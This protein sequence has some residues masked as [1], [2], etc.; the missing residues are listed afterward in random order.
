MD[1]PPVEPILV[2]D[3]DPTCRL[4]MTDALE[5]AGYQVD[6]ASDGTGALA[7]IVGQRYALVVADV[8]MPRLHGLALVAELERVRPGVPALLISAFSD[9]RTRAAA[10]RL[11]VP[12]L[13]KPFHAEALVGRVRELLRARAIDSSA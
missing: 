2:V 11:G 8:S 4:I 10:R 13:T 5:R 12:L 6:A 1:G 7:R 9:E 3:D